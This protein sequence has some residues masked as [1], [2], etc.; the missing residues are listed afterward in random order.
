MSASGDHR[1][2]QDLLLW[3]E[4]AGVG[5]RL[6]DED[7]AL[8]PKLTEYTLDRLGPE[9]IY[10]AGDYLDSALVGPRWRRWRRS[11][12]IGTRDGWEI[13]WV[14]SEDLTFEHLASIDDLAVKWQQ[15]R[16]KGATAGDFAPKAIG[17]LGETGWVVFFYHE[18]HLRAWDPFHR[19]F[20]GPYA[21]DVGKYWV[22][23][24]YPDGDALRFIHLWNARAVVDLIGP[25]G[26]FSR[27]SGIGE[28]GAIHCKRRL[29]PTHELPIYRAPLR[30]KILTEDWRASRG[31]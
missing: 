24:P 10:R 13:Q 9:F 25:H 14:V 17:A 4:A 31:R 3:F 12:S 16:G 27:G 15:E 18:G 7:L 20:G 1:K 5:A 21:M 29:H 23:G 19:P 2:E 28:R 22:A 30:R 8:Y 11:L 6:S 26:L